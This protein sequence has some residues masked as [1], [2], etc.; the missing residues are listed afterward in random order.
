MCAQCFSYGGVCFFAW[1]IPHME[2][3][4][5]K[6]IPIIGRFALAK[7]QLHEFDIILTHWNCWMGFR[8][9]QWASDLIVHPDVESSHKAANLGVI[10]THT[11]SSTTVRVQCVTYPSF[12]IFH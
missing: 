9:S 5:V 6:P 4:I 3:A 12:D 8:A 11:A 1:V 7:N 10:G 2:N